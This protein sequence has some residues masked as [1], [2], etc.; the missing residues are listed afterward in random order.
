MHRGEEVYYEV[1]T[2]DLNRRLIYACRCDE[3]LKAKPEGFTR[4]GYTE[5]S[6]GLLAYLEKVKHLRLK[7]CRKKTN[8]EVSNRIKKRRRSRVT[9]SVT[10]KL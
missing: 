4:L 10:L 3:G 7:H 2:R 9:E 8:K 5:K 6:V 1:I